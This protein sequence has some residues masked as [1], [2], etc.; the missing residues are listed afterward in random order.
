MA[1]FF[2]FETEKIA[3]TTFFSR[4]NYGFIVLEYTEFS[5]HRFITEQHIVWRVL[6]KFTKGPSRNSRQSK[7]EKSKF[8][9]FSA[10]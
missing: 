10:G 8:S 6:L 2:V 5:T 7:Q 3:K 1:T 4:K 9:L